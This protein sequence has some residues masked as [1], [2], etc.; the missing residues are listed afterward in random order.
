[1]K[2]RIVGPKLWNLVFSVLLNTLTKVFLSQAWKDFGVE[3][4]T[5]NNEAAKL[6]DAVLTQVLLLSFGTQF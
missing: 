2:N 5:T 1:M 3:L 6:F 4:S